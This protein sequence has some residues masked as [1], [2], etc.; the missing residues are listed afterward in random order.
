VLV[1]KGWFLA[2]HGFEYTTIYNSGKE[3]WGVMLENTKS[4]KIK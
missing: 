4:H 2:R 1:G 3:K